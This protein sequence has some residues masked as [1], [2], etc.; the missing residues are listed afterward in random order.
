ML[1]HFNG[2]QNQV[3][4][5]GDYLLDPLNAEQQQANSFKG[6]HRQI[7]PTK[8]YLLDPPEGKQ[9]IAD[10]TANYLLD[11]LK[12][13]QKQADPTANH[14]LDRFKG[15][16]QQRIP[17]GNY[18]LDPSKGKQPQANSTGFAAAMLTYNYAQPVD[19]M[20]NAPNP[21]QASEKDPLA[22]SADE[23]E[24]LLDENER[25]CQNLYI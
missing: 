1:D 3:D 24:M 22:L 21:N 17:T 20:L 9:P 7:A 8:N 19:P 12:Y 25:R 15:K 4:R 2:R 18:L 10:S 6:K 16:Q 13:K 14:L 11:P 5:A 23:I